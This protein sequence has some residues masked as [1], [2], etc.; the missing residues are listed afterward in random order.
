MIDDRGLGIDQDELM[1]YLKENPD[2]DLE[3]ILDMLE[4]AILDEQDAKKGNFHD[5]VKNAS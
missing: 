4:D 3:E 5:L 1:Y 2:W